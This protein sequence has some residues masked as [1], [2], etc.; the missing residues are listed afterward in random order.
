MLFHSL[1]II[2]DLLN[3]WQ[4]VYFPQEAPPADERVE[5]LVAR[6]SEAINFVAENSQ[7]RFSI[8]KPDLAIAVAI[9]GLGMGNTQELT[10]ELWQACQEA[11]LAVP[12]EEDLDWQEQCLQRV[13][14][15]GCGWKR[16]IDP[17]S[18]P[19]ERRW[20][21]AI[22]A[23]R[24][25]IEDS[26][27]Q[28]MKLLQSVFIRERS[29]LHLSRAQKRSYAGLMV[30]ELIQARCSCDSHKKGCQGKCDCC[31][32]EHLLANW[33]PD[34]CSLQ[35]FIAQAVRGTAED[36]LRSGAFASSMLYPRLQEDVGITLGNVEFKVCAVCYEEEIATAVKEEKELKIKDLKL[37]EANKCPDCDTPADP[38]STY[39]KARKNWF[40]LP[41]DM[42]GAYELVKRWRC[43]GD[44]NLFHI[45][46]SHCPLCNKERSQ[47]STAVW[48][49][50]PSLRSIELDGETIRRK[51]LQDQENNR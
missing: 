48:V 11:V 40:L 14:A 1:S 39:Y 31:R 17:S 41:Y 34:V 32:D 16:P 50:H 29:L 49:Y 35:A 4:K 21:G 18:S 12:F 43:T 22:I 37:F 27:Q 7:G 30:L 20:Y 47:R 8:I 28:T 33:E 44:K 5:C 38:N 25:R 19:W 46:R 15:V 10:P 45:T 26:I 23:L 9:V 24:K 13:T 3:D 51:Y 36:R 42:G 2:Q 6:Y